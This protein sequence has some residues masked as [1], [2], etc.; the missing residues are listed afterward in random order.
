M[1]GWPTDWDE[2]KRGKDCAM[3]AQGRV[4]DNG[5]GVRIFAGR[6]SDAYLQRADVGQRGYTIV[7]WRGPHVSDPT[8]LSEEDATT[9]FAEVLRVARALERHYRPVKMNLAMLGNELPHLHTHLIPR[10]PDD[11]SPGRPARFTREEL[12]PSRLAESDV[13]TDAAALRALV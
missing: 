4:D 9:Y 2:R 1:S 5:F 7:I 8:E 12:P 11:G 6:V 3:C 10:Y 13:V